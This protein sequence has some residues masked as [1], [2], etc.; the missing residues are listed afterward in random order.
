MTT[1]KEAAEA[2]KEPLDIDTHRKL[3][4]WLPLYVR[5][6]DAEQQAKSEKEGMG[7]A[8]KDYLEAHPDDTLY[9][10]ETGLQAVLQERHG[11]PAYDLVTL[12]ENDPLLFGRLLKTGCLQ[13]NAAA[14]KAQ[15]A[16]VG[17]VEK[18][19]FPAPITTALQVK[20]V[21]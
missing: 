4:E 9:D 17:G 19:A 2:L 6:R 15:G 3:V 14:V 5:A 1:R 7:K 18:Y 8:F 13:V 10:G 12:H 11:T 21:K 16:Q 20:E